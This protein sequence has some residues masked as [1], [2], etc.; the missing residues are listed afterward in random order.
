M[1]VHIGTYTKEEPAD[2]NEEVG[3]PVGG[4]GETVRVSPGADGEQFADVEPRNRTC[5]VCQCFVCRI[6]GGDLKGAAA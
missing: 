1:Y 5:I 3:R 6:G 2:A 4:H